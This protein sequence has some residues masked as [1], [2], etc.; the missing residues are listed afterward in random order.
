MPEPGAEP[1][2][3]WRVPLVLAALALAVRAW[4]PGPTTQTFDEQYWLARSEVFSDA[5]ADG[6]WD[7]ATAVSDEV[8][9]LPGSPPC[10][11]TPPATGWPA[12]DGLGIGPAPTTWVG[13]D[14]PGLAL[15]VATG[16]AVGIGLLVHVLGLLVG[17]R[18]A[19]IAGGPAGGR[20]LL[21]R[22]HRASSAPTGCRWRPAPPWPSPPSP[23]PWCRPDPEASAP[24]R[25]L[26]VLAGVAAG[27]ATLTKLNVPLAF[28]PGLLA[29]I[30]LPAAGGD[31]HGLPALRIRL[32]R[33]L[34]ALAVAA[35]VAVVV[36]VVLWP[37]LVTDLGVQV[38][39]MAASGTWWSATGQF[40]LG[41]AV[42][43]PGW[44]YYPV[45]FA[46]R[47]TPWMLLGLVGALPSW[48]AP[49]AG[50][51]V[52][53]PPGAV[54]AA[55]A[56]GSYAVTL[57]STAKTFDRY[58][59]PLWPWAAVVVGL[60]VAEVADRVR[61]PTGT[62]RAAGRV[63]L[64]VTTLITVARAPY[65]I[66]WTNPLLG[67]GP[68]AEERILL[69][70]GEGYEQLGATIA[71]REGPTA[72]RTSRS[73]SDRSLRRGLPV[74]RRRQRPPPRRP[75][76]PPLRGPLR[77]RAPAGRTDDPGRGRRPSR[78]SPSTAS[79]TPSCGGGPTPRPGSDLSLRRGGPGSTRRSARGRRG[80]G[81]WA[82]S[83]AR[84]R[85]RVMSGWRCVG[86]S[87]GSGSNV[88][89]R[90]SR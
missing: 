58:S 51:L 14:P 8:V 88:S 2:R 74:R 33:P 26:L 12:C 27:L 72:A 52:S 35:G 42:S 34:G 32:R 41:E 55:V 23:P 24:S 56:T 6:R 78:S 67:G 7:D 1:R 21:R 43:H 65:A 15:A 37:A 57:V 79:P 16:V 13:P 75:A 11:P 49:G 83:R 44:R 64:A 76:T 47:A 60:A 59:L 30:V 17:R 86:S 36:C 31:R 54:V 80:G 68:T 22:R 3:A 71:E 70:W 5:L 77:Q 19:T 4:N 84:S 61:V 45:A 66:S 10:G 85:A 69:G 38:D 48:S 62:V 89:P 63:A 73:E 20:P 53:G 50:R 29:V 18:A 90:T 81:R 25:G 87:T 40:F 9:T 82:P 46:T 28:V 39:A